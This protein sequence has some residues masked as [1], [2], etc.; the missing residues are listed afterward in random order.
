MKIAI[1]RDD[2]GV[3][4]MNLVEGMTLDDVP[5]EVAK[6]E[7]GGGVAVSWRETSDDEIPPTREF[8][9]AW[10]DTGTEIAV[11]PVKAA[12]LNREKILAALPAVAALSTLLKTADGPGIDAWQ[13]ANANSLPEIRDFIRTLLKLLAARL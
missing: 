1:T 6:W 8:R 9:N 5:G 10:Y 7:T 11:D 13:T 4:I 12:T 3:S 2:G